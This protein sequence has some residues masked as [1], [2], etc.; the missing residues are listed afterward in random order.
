[1][2]KKALFLA[3]E[4]GGIELVV[5]GARRLVS[6]LNESEGR[7]HVE[8]LAASIA[9]L[10]LL[11]FR[12]RALRYALEDKIDPAILGERNMTARVEKTDVVLRAWSD[13]RRTQH[14]RDELERIA[15]LRRSKR[16][17]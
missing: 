2:A 5:D 3:Q 4:V 6:S 8:T 13:E 16:S 10:E 17:R 1:M 12:V 14:L 15:R 9:T 7:E 11:R